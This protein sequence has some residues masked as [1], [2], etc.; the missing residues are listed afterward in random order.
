M[1]KLIALL[2]LLLIIVH[3]IPT[4]SICQSYLKMLSPS[5]STSD[6]PNIPIPSLMYSGFSTNNPG[7]KYEC[8]NKT[9]PNDPYHYF[10]VG[11]KNT[12]INVDTFMG[13]CMPASCTKE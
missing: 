4:A 12:T 5:I 6:L 9:P 13:I 1:S 10:L 11:I 2:S 7:Q 8:E 3:S